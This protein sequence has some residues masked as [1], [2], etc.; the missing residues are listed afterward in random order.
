M[1]CRA[2]VT[3]F[4]L[5]TLEDI[6]KL[7]INHFKNETSTSIRA[8]SSCWKCE[9]ERFLLKINW[10]P[11]ITPSV[12]YH[13]ALQW[14]LK[15]CC[16]R[17]RKSISS[18]SLLTCNLQ[19]SVPALGNTGEVRCDAPIDTG[20]VLLLAV[21]GAQKEQRAGR[22]QDMVGREL[23]RLTVLVPV[24]GR[25]R[26]PVRFAVQRH[27]FIFRHDLVVGMLDDPWCTVL[28]CG[29]RQQR[30][31]RIDRLIF[32]WKRENVTSP[33]PHRRCYNTRFTN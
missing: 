4:I 8:H 13:D 17:F 12:R 28:A 30:G 14:R 29:G 21:Q 26:F 18:T 22:E 27:G 24:D 19:R 16:S 7:N 3:G 15:R 33:S 32:P 2:N 11:I 23:H 5:I 9:K 31:N 6:Q 1:T 10:M 20:I 25:I